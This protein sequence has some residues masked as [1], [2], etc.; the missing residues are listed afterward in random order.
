MYICLHTDI[1]KTSKRIVFFSLKNVFEINPKSNYSQNG[2]SES[3]NIIPSSEY[4]EPTKMFLW[5]E[6]YTKID[7]RT[8]LW[9]DKARTILINGPVGWRRGW[10]GAT[11]RVIT[12]RQRILNCLHLFEL[13]TD[14]K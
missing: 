10:H 6:M 13:P 8:I 14:L 3:T 7:F 2:N 11:S 5:A 12:R 9:T 4:C 1:N